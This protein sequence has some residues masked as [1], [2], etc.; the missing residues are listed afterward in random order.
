MPASNVVEVSFTGLAI[1]TQFVFKHHPAFIFVKDSSSTAY[2]VG[3]DSH[4]DRY[5]SLGPEDF[6]RPVFRPTTLD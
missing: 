1:G 6:V 5:T 3:A 4:D 2:L